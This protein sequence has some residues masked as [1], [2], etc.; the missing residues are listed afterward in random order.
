MECEVREQAGR[1]F[2]RGEMSIYTASQLKSSLFD[3]L[4]SRDGPCRLQLADVTAFDTAG[5]QIILLV[6]RMARAGGRPFAILDP[7]PVVRETLELVG[8]RDLIGKA[9]ARKTSRKKKGAS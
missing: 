2:V 7:S 8:L 9:V 3:H 5:L 1:L 4:T 6:S